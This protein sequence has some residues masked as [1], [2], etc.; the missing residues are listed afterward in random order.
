MARLRYKQR[1]NGTGQI[2]FCK[3]RKTPYRVNITVGHTIHPVTGKKKPIIQSLGYYP[4]KQKAEEVLADYNRCPHDLSHKDMTFAELYEEWLPIYLKDSTSD[5]Y[6]RTLESAYKYCHL[7]YHKKIR[8]LRVEDFKYCLDNGYVIETKG[9]NKGN[10]KMASD[11]TKARMKS[12][13]NLMFEYAN[14]KDWV[15]KNYAKSFSLDEKMIDNIR[16]NKKGAP[17]FLY[18]DFELLWKAYRLGVEDVD[19]VL[20][21]IYTGFR[22]SELINIDLENVFLDIE[23]G[24]IKGGM[25][26]DAGK[27]R[28]VPI[29]PKIRPLIELQYN[30]A[31][32]FGNGK[33]FFDTRGRNSNVMTYDK[34]SYR[35]EKVIKYLGFKSQYTTH[36]CR[37]TFI[38]LAK[39]Y[40]MNDHLLKLIVGHADPDITERTYTRRVLSQLEDAMRVIPNEIDEKY[41][42]EDLINELIKGDT[43][44]LFR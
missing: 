26:T 36:S 30:K 4:T 17:A 43:E 9:K 6:K 13:F 44:G 35:F 25:K 1:G 21:Q 32:E 41:L 38:T 11:N 7:I 10:K 15:I 22:A 40:N 42:A 34:Y 16:A 8:D 18:K 12:I 23:D 33:L 5:N 3:G 39:A 37:V 28:F 31:K 14:E 29:H 27:N 2:I 24:F 20:I 19:L